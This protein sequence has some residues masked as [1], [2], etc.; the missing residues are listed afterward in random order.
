MG[1]AIDSFE[2]PKIKKK[3]V[4]FRKYYPEQRQYYLET[5]KLRA[6]IDFDGPIHK[7]SQG[8]NG[9]EIYDSPSP[10]AK[11]FIDWLK[12]QGYEIVIFT[13]RASKTNA[14]EMGQDYKKEILKV[15]N[16][17]NLYNIPYDLI[18]AEKLAANFYIDDKAIHY[19][20]S[21][22]DVKNEVNKRMNTSL[23]G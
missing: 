7:Y 15:E 8:W 2:S 11:E 3:K 13:S 10:G 19:N 9:G 21:W 18:T 12:N 5:G 6:M 23:G 14:E 1:F 16:W 20:G 22:D 17:L 4:V